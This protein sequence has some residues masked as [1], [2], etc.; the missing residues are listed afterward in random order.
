MAAEMLVSAYEAIFGEIQTVPASKP[1][2]TEDIN[3]WKSSGFFFW[4]ES[5]NLEPGK[6][7]NWDDWSFMPAIVYDATLRSD[8][9][10]QE[11]KAPYG[12]VVAA[13]AALMWLPRM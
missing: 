7:G 11:S 13:L 5:G 4:S 1:K 8:M 9:K 10:L 2:D 3:A 6:T 12:S